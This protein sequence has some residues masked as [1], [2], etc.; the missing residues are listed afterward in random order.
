MNPAIAAAIAAT[1]NGAF[2]LW[3]IYANKPEGWKPSH[4]DYLNLI[5]EVNAAT[6]EARMEAAR[7]RLN[8]PP[9]VIVHPQEPQAPV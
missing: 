1:I 9:D 2:E 7:V 3:R 5:E 4:A 6:V 8:L